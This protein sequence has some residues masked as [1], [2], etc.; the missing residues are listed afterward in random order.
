MLRVLLV[1][2]G[3]FIGSILRY[4][5]SGIAQ[6]LADQSSFPVGTILVNLTGCFLIGIFS[7]L[8]ES[9]GVFSSAARTLLFIGVLG[10]YTTFSTFSSETI[11]LLR[12]GQV[13]MAALNIIIQVGGGLVLVW[14]GR[15]AGQLVWR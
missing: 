11:T 3:G 14:A 7:Q 2:L 9:R 4:L 6:R 13:L 15:T 10:G 8:A 5:L 1:G 12:G